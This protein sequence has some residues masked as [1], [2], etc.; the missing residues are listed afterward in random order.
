MGP[1]QRGVK[2]EVIWVVVG[3]VRVEPVPRYRGGKK[4]ENTRI[5]W[6]MTGQGLGHAKRLNSLLGGAAE[7]RI[8]RFQDAK[9]VCGENGTRMS[10][11]GGLGGT[12][13][14]KTT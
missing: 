5:R 12:A 6:A 10:S 1:R 7:K 4:E 3:G 2:V 8:H 9:R 14:I 11:K 13:W